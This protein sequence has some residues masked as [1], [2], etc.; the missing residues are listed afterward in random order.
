VAVVQD[1]FTHK[2]Y[3]KHHHETEYNK[4]KT[5]YKEQITHNN[6]NT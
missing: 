4:M 5:E 6:K 2:Q 1:T 3:T